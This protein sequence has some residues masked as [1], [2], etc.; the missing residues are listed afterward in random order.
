MKSDKKTILI[1]EDEEGVRVS[2]E[3]VLEDYYN[4]V[5]CNDAIIGLD[6]L[7]KNRQTIDL[8]ILDIRMPRMDGLSALQE[9]RNLYPDLKTMM[10]TA[11][12]YDSFKERA[13]ELGTNDYII[14][15]FEIDDFLARIA[16]IIN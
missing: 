5:F 4:L 6:Y 11:G 3:L 9:I 15:P 7:S 10:L 14:K 12:G 13:E 2:L 1:I 8:V 16:K